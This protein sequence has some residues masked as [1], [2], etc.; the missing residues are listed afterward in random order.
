[1]L[2]SQVH[3]FD[4]HSAVLRKICDLPPQLQET[5]GIIFYHNL[6]W[7]FNDSGNKP[8]LYGIDTTSGTIQREVRLRDAHNYDWEAIDQDPKFIYIGD[9]GNNGKSRSKFLIYKIPKD[10]I[11]EQRTQTLSGYSTIKF[12]VSEGNKVTKKEFDAESMLVYNGSIFIYTK[13][14]DKLKTRALKIPVKPGKYKVDKLGTF[15]VNGLVT[16]A[17]YMNNKLFLLGYLNYIPFIS[18]LETNRQLN[19]VSAFRRFDFPNYYRMQTEG[20]TYDKGKFFI[21]CENAYLKQGLYEV[22][23][24]Q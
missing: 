6:L 11:Q 19:P 2:F 13:D 8:V 5:S 4:K 23:F 24:K 1:M 20:L 18:V 10:S 15:D 22:I 3:V 9:F 14:W 7:T 21:S 16:A 17:E 12:E